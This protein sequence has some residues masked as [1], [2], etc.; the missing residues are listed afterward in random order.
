MQSVKRT[1]DVEERDAETEECDEMSTPHTDPSV[2]CRLCFSITHLEPV[3]RSSLDK[4]V[5][6]TRLVKSTTGVKLD[7][8]SDAACSI[9][10]KCLDKINDFRRFRKLCQ[11]LN[12][13]VL[14]ERTDAQPSLEDNIDLTISDHEENQLRQEDIDV[15]QNSEEDDNEDSDVEC[16]GV[17]QLPQAD[18]AGEET[19]GLPFVQIGDELFRCNQCSTTTISSER[20][21]THIYAAHPE[22]TVCD[23]TPIR[24]GQKVF[25]KCGSCDALFTQKRNIR[26]HSLKYHNKNNGP[27]VKLLCSIP[28]CQST[29]IEP[30]GLHRHLK[31]NHYQSK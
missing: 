11:L 6:L 20:M 9:C 22:S 24:I 15:D 13:V 31:M 25:Y 28:G 23:P 26:K 5:R 2:Y 17:I 30:H 29:F 18:E 12:N 16:T 14:R 21:I 19:N 8:K 4:N 27:T 7:S 1:R 3:F 10:R